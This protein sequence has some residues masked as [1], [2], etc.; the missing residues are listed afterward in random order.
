M[1]RLTQF[2]IFIASLLSL[3][4]LHVSLICENNIDFT[5]NGIINKLININK[6][7]ISDDINNNSND[8]LNVENFSN[9]QLENLRKIKIRQQLHSKYPNFNDELRDL[10]IG[11]LN[12]LH[13]TDTHAWYMGHLNQRQ[14]SSDW[15]DL[16]SFIFN[17]KE[18]LNNNNIDNDGQL[19]DLLV[20]DTGDRH[21]G[22]GLSDLSFPNG[23][24]SN[25]I[26]SQLS[27]DID[28]I[29]VGNHELYKAEVSLLEFNTIV[30]KF[31]E[32][33]ISTN[34]EI[35]DKYQNKFVVFGN[36]KYRYFETKLNKFKI[37]S[38]SF[39]FD[40]KRY[41]ELIK[42]TPIM[43]L[44][45]Q[46][47]FLELLNDFKLN[48]KVDIIVIFGHIPIDHSWL[49]LF[50]L[51]NT[52][53][54]FFP[55]TPIQY[56]GGHSHIR[57]FTVL[58]KLSTGLQSGRYCETL[59][60][61]SIK[62]LPNTNSNSTLTVPTSTSSS[63]WVEENI[64]RKYIDFNLHSFMYHTNKT[65]LTD[66][67]TE[68]G[69]TISNEIYNIANKEL[70]LNEK[71]GFIPKNYYMEA[72]NYPSDNSLLS[73]LSD[74][75]LVQLE[76]KICNVPLETKEEEEENQFYKS[77][78]DNNNSRIIIINTGSIRYDLYKGLFTTNTQFTISPFKNQWKIL[79][80]IPKEI[81]LEIAPI[82]NN[83]SYILNAINKQQE[84]DKDEDKILKFSTEIEDSIPI[85][86]NLKNSYQRQLEF[87]NY[88]LNLKNNKLNLKN[89]KLQSILINNENLKNDLSLSKL[90][91][92]YVTFDD[93]GNDGDDTIHRPL[94]YFKIPNVIQSYEKN[95]D[96]NEYIDI[97]Y[98]DFIEW[99]ILLALK[100]SIIKNNN[101][102]NINNNND[103]K[104]YD[105]YIKNIK[106]YNNCVDDY[107]VGELLKKFVINNWN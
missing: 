28:L 11:K 66:F 97:I 37:L 45:K 55:N 76:N 2:Y 72:T 3:L 96:N 90:S 32:K 86:K 68:K 24:Y 101:I 58:D 65:S 48:Y 92:G 85:I 67:N 73:L 35:Y 10:K 79:P 13:T 82:L 14:Y 102:N 19:S 38:F 69:L 41:N 63:S 15:G 53:R 40:F 44:I 36:S 17:F 88:N 99:N 49:E 34:V 25:R 47:W 98:Y 29:T 107:N 60:F 23:L 20:I 1:Q 81:A 4:I 91:Y 103:Q 89:D 64:D 93:F 80:K 77:S 22:Q 21:D 43:V 54:S 94:N 105:D 87:K 18:L 46:D 31:K 39:L 57:D 16:S 51:H 78:D 75:I 56:F 52:I 61:L 100:K 6:D 83:H 74:K 71:F 50:E 12:F 106:M 5:Y 30:P 27:D 26:Y 8:S 9:L 59:G 95:E 62:D 70:N 33:F 84:Q 42:V 104:L 7:I